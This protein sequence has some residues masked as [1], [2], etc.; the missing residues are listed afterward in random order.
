MS[1]IINLIANFFDWLKRKYN[2]RDVSMARP[3]ELELEQGTV[4][5]QGFPKEIADELSAHIKSF[6]KPQEQTTAL[7]STSA[8]EVKVVDKVIMTDKA[9]G[10]RINKAQNKVEMVT[11]V[12]NADT[13]EAQV[14]S[15]VPADGMKDAIIKFKMAACDL[16]FV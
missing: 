9:I 15:V 1:S 11:V 14:E 6:G 13:K 2:K 4:F 10:L 8:D 16:N 12:Y 7:A 3:R 5:L